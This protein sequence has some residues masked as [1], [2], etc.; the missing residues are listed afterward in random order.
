MALVEING[1]DRLAP[2]QRPTVADRPLVK[3]GR[4]DLSEKTVA[5]RHSAAEEKIQRELDARTWGKMFPS[6]PPI[7]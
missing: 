2:G 6:T 3:K 1:A 5:L 7:G 4:R